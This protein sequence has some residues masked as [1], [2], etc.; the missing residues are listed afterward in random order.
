MR[1]LLPLPQAGTKNALL[2][3]LVQEPD[4]N[5]AS[6]VGLGGMGDVEPRGEGI[7]ISSAQSEDMLHSM[8]RKCASATAGSVMRHIYTRRP[9]ATWAAW[10]ASQRQHR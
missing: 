8:E 4:R 1:L 5:V 2:E 7:S 3:A 6:K 9:A 10:R